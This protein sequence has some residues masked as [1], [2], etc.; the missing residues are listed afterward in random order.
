MPLMREIHGHT[1]KRTNRVGNNIVV[2]LKGSLKG[3]PGPR[4]VLPVDEYLASV[5]TRFCSRA[6]AGQLAT[7]H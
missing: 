6:N 3:K 5:K 2:Y 1:I 4:L 7:F